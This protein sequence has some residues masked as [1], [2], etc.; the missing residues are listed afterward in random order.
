MTGMIPDIMRSVM[1]VRADSEWCSSYICCED[2]GWRMPRTK[3]TETGGDG[4]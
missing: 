4:G 2:G 3:K 1:W